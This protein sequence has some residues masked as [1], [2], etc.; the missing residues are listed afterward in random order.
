MTTRFKT[1]WIALIVLAIG[2]NS[3]KSLV[4]VRD[5]KPML[6]KTY[7]A[8]PSSDSSNLANGNW[9]S[10]FADTC[11]NKLID[12][13]LVNNQEL[14]KVWME[15]IISNS[16]V[17]ARSGEYLPFVNAGLGAGVDK[18]GRYT[19]QGAMEATTELEPGKAIPEYVPDFQLGVSA[20]WEVD[21]WHKLRNAKES[22]VKRYLASV[23]GRNF[24]ITQVVAE[25]A[26]S[27]YELQ[28][29][30]KQLQI[31]SQTIAL[32]TD[33]L[34][35]MRQEKNAARLTELPIRKFE[36][37]VFATQSMQFVIQQKIVLAENRINFLLGRMPQPIERSSG[38]L[39]PLLSNML[40]VG[41]PTDLLENRCDIRQAEQELEAAKLD[42]KVAKANFYPSLG[43]KMGL[44]LNA[45]HPTYLINP[46]SL[47]I[48]L[49]GDLFAPVVNRRSIKAQYNS[50]NA[51]QMQAVFTY[52]QTVLQAVIEVNNQL[53]GISNL[54]KSY[55]LK[56][57]QV[58][59]L[60]KAIKVTNSLFLSARAD[61]MEVLMTQRD[62][63]ESKM[64]LIEIR[65]DQLI[66][67]V[68]LYKALGGGW[69]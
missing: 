22:A 12:S 26:S 18:A 32:Q 29:L 68:Q 33:A 6:P 61:Y 34:K 40:Q 56:E 1:Y 64:Q 20:R 19:T 38:D 69:K 67:Q 4:T 42:T 39:K 57:Q 52:E 45:M 48:G 43:L 46:Q 27:Y 35:I 59:S 58:E 24:L 2:L 30:D 5:E 13:A 16:E 37:E 49:A 31:L 3:C 55:E 54:S 60:S 8:V 41:V 14:N 53:S 23:E 17:L 51:K 44:G 10:Y 47:A 21:I 65:R 28:A 62:L 15:L 36:A 50:A 7:S 25:I 9:R 11:L 66:S 63:L